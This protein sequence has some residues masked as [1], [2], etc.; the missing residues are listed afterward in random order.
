[1][2]CST[3][4]GRWNVLDKLARVYSLTSLI[5]PLLTTPFKGVNNT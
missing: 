4:V 5:T 2:W 1:M 3:N